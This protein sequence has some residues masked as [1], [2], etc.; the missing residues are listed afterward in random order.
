MV[1]IVRENSEDIIE[2]NLIAY[3]DKDG[4]LNQEEINKLEEKRKVRKEKMETKEYKEGL[5]NVKKFYTNMNILPLALRTDKSLLLNRNETF[6]A[7]ADNCEEVVKYNVNP[8]ILQGNGAAYS[9]V[10]E[11]NEN[12]ENAFEKNKVWKQDGSGIKSGII[13]EESSSNIRG[14]NETGEESIDI[15]AIKNDEGA[16]KEK[17]PTRRM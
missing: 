7:L 3:G 13:E 15:E 17:A 6:K 8:N 5:E 2:Q 1:D 14:V 9:E 10:I 4:Q 12:Q 16:I 11:N